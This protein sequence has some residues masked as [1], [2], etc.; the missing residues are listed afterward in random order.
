MV[1]A[2][3]KH[4]RIVQVGTQQRSAPHF[5]RAVEIVKEGKIGAV[6]SVRCWNVGNAAPE[7]IGN[8][9]DTDPPADLDW[10][11]WLGPAPKVAFNKNRFGVHPEG[12]SH[13]RWFWDYAGGMMTD[14]GVHLIDIVQ[15]A[16]N[17]D[18]P[19]AV[20]AVGGK[21]HLK[22]N[23]ETPDTILATYQYPGLRDVVREPGLQRPPAER[24][25]LR[26]LLLRHRRDAVRRSGGLSA[27]AGAAQPQ[28]AAA[29][30]ARVSGPDAQHARQ[31]DARPQ[32]H[33]LRQ[34]AAGAD[35]RHRNRPPLVEHAIL[36]NLA[37]RSGASVTWDGKAEKVTN[38]NRKAAELV[39]VAVSTRRGSWWSDKGGAWGVWG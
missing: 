9:P 36:G 22:D 10:D 21:F 27:R 18:A 17:V 7:G 16:M 15:W 2:A 6:T 32:L 1:D 38:G 20:S 33:R 19:L 24:P 8:P 14:W 35:L 34:V 5:Q 29:R 30:T 39:D 11:M 31:P 28:G 23:R 26:H 12:F 4:Q 25:R 37:L 13:F 3:R